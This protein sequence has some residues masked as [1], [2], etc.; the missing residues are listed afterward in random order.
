MQVLLA[1][2]VIPSIR[3]DATDQ[4]YPQ[5][6][7]EWQVASVEPNFA[8]YNEGGDASISSTIRADDITA[9]VS[10]WV[11]SVTN[12]QVQ[13]DVLK[14]LTKMSESGKATDWL[15]I[16]GGVVGAGLGIAKA[17]M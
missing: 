15:G 5:I 3:P 7:S 12:G 2:V 16:L 17:F 4:K 1:Q 14:T 11:A 9:A 13:S 6:V 10:G 8:T